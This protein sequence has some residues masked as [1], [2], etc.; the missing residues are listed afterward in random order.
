MRK[1]LLQTAAAILPLLLSAPSFAADTG[2]LIVKVTGIKNDKGTARI[3]VFNSP[4]TF[5]VKGTAAQPF[6]K[7]GV[8]IANGEATATFTNLPYGDYAIKYFH[9]EDNSGSFKTN[10]LGMPKVEF[11]FSGNGDAKRG[12]PPF[13]KGKF[14][15][16][17][18]EVTVEI[19]TQHP[20]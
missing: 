19:K 18:P 15:V 16:N 4:E 13:N 10:M 6:L 5:A 3:A 20:L 17:S 14:S 2:N 7:Q 9:D 8:S 12:A 1:Q 11:G